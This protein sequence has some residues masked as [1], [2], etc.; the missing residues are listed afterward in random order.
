ANGGRLSTRKKLVSC[1][2]AAS[3]KRNIA[4]S[5]M[6]WRR[7][8]RMPPRMGSWQPKRLRYGAATPPAVCSSSVRRA[9]PWSDLADAEGKGGGAAEDVGLTVFA[10]KRTIIKNAC[11]R[12]NSW[13][14]A[15]QMD[16][17]RWKNGS[18]PSQRRPERNA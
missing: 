12:R 4:Q 1:H 6:A 5:F 8:G 11:L 18:M 15:R 3:R 13:F 7:E 17:F 14:S 2:I 9:D 16:A 10:R